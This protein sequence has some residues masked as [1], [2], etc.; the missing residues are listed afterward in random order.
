VFEVKFKM[1]GVKGRNRE[2]AP[3]RLSLITRERKGIYQVEKG[4]SL[5]L[6]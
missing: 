4:N 3:G 6:A 5:T 1:A 2:L